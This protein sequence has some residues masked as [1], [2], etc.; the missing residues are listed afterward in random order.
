[1]ARIIISTDQGESVMD[2][3]LMYVSPQVKAEITIAIKKAVRID[4]ARLTMSEW[5]DEYVK[6][7]KE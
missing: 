4:H 1:M 3:N 7:K 5:I 6:E 2:I